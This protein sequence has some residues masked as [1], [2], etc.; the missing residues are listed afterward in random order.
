MEY[1]ILKYLHILSATFLFGTGIG[2]AFFMLMAYISKNIETIKYTTKHVVLA[3][4]VFTTPAVILQPI[5]GIWLMLIL[6][7]PFNTLWFFLV[8]GLYLL[9]GLCWLPVVLIQYRLHKMVVN[10]QTENLPKQFH[11]LIRWWIALGIP[12]FISLLVVY[13]LMVTKQGLSIQF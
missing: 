12:A 11:L 6:H 7:Y 10:M 9:A 1:L 4:W 2:T 5:T 13:W 3:D 8:I